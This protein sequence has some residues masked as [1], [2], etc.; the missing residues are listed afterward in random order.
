M[1]EPQARD[2][3]K[4]PHPPKASMFRGFKKRWMVLL[5]NADV[6]CIRFST[7]PRPQATLI[8]F[9]L[10]AHSSTLKLAIVGKMLMLRSIFSKMEYEWRL[11]ELEKRVASLE[12]RKKNMY[13]CYVMGLCLFLVAVY[14]TTR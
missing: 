8:A 5:R 6:E 10:G 13:L 3:V 12:Q 4:G 11:S 9:S 7:F 14:V 1:E 2:I